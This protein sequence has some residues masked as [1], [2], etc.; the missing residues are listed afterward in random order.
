MSGCRNA[1][2]G[3]I[4]SWTTALAAVSALAL[5][6]ATARAGYTL[7]DLG[8][9]PGGSA[10]TA[11]SS[12]GTVAGYEMMGPAQ[13]HATLF[14]D[15][16]GIDLGTLGGDASLALGTASGGRVVG[17]ARLPDATRHAFL[18]QGGV[19]RDLGTLGGPNSQAFAINDAGVVVGSSWVPTQ[20]E[21]VPMTWTEAGGMTTIAVPQVHGGQALGINDAGQVV[22]YFIDSVMVRPFLYENGAAHSLPTLGGAASKAYGIS[23]GGNIAGYALT[24]D[25]VYPKFHA[26]IWRKGIIHDLGA[27]AAGHGSALAVND[28]GIAVGFSYDANFNMVAVRWSEGSNVDLNQALPPGSPWHL[29]LASDITEDGVISGMGTR[30]GLAR[31]FALVPDGYDGSTWGL[32]TGFSMRAW[33][34]P[35]RDAGTVELVLDRAMSGPL[36]LYDVTGRRVADLASGPFARGRYTIAV[37]SGVLAAL[38]PG[39]YY[40]RLDGEMG[41]LKHRLVV[42]K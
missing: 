39:V 24:P 9:V 12:D 31:A 22:G 40:A 33:P 8:G 27:M 17:W 23:R 7:I 28:G 41:A 4:R 11:I 38:R 36:R 16:Q 5:G 34:Q 19:M 30:D 15:G 10:A 1:R 18:Y 3:R 14:L 32:A 29:S 2:R 42:V 20:P 6:A 25:P 37:P 13:P 35:M 21:E 26:V